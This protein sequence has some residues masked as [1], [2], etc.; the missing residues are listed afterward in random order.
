MNKNIG[1]IDKVL[2]IVVA[3]I[4]IGYGVINQ[5]LLGLIAIVP[6]ATALVSWCPLYTILGIKT[7]CSVQ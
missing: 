7:T 5:S 1:N 2:R 3:I 4:I 6:L